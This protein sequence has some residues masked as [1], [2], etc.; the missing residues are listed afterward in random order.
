M[1]LVAGRVGCPLLLTSGQVC[2]LFGEY[3]GE[4][5]YSKGQNTDK[6]NESL[7]ILFDRVVRKPVDME[8]SFSC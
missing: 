6:M 2:F 3:G 5:L 8:A 4:M 1:G 7:F